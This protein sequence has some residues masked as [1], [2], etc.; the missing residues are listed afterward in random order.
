MSL[1]FVAFLAFV[2]LEGVVTEEL[3]CTLHWSMLCCL[4][5]LWAYGLS[6][7]SFLKGLLKSGH[8]AVK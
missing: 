1:D 7:C 2:K 6:L 5:F 3:F 8:A 4:T